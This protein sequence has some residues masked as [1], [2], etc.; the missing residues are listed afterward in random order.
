VAVSGEQ[1]PAGTGFSSVPRGQQTRELR[2]AG[3]RERAE[4]KALAERARHR[5]AERRRIPVDARPAGRQRPGERE[6]RRFSVV[7]TSKALARN[8]AMA[9]GLLQAMRPVPA[10]HVRFK[11]LAG[12][13]EVSCTCCELVTVLVNQSALCECGRVFW[14][15]GEQVRVVK[16]EQLEEADDGNV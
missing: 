11:P 9:Q 3:E 10:S 12:A 15:V 2:A 14:N 8:A 7:S 5:M 6:L 13:A 16:T 4:V 1:L